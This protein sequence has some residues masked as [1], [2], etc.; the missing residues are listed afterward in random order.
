MDNLQKD[1]NHA[2]MSSTQFMA[3]PTLFSAKTACP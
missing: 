3:S 2:S 1:K